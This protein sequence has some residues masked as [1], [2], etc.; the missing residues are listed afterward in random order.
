MHVIKMGE[1]VRNLLSTK[2]F[3]ISF[4]VTAAGIVR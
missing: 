2:G 3:N 4:L 1:D